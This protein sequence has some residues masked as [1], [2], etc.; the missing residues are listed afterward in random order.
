MRKLGLDAFVAV[1]NAHYLSDTSAASVAIVAGRKS[2]L[3][4]SRME[5]DRAGQQSSIKDIRAYFPSRVPLR[6]GERASFGKLERVIAGCLE[7]LGAKEIGFDEINPKTQTK[8]RGTYE[9]SYHELPEL[10]WDLREIKTKREMGWLRKSAEIARRGMKRAAELI[11]EGRSELEIAAE[12]EYE[13]R[14]SGSEGASF[15]TIVASGKNSWLPHAGATGKR[16]RR[17]ELVIVDLGATYRGYASDMTRT[18]A[19]EPTQKQK[20]LIRVAKRAQRAAL[21][22]IKSGVEAAKIDETARRVFCRAGYERFCLHGSGHGVG[23]DIH[24]PPSLSA[25]SEDILRRG[26]VVTVE[27]GVYVRGVGGARFEDMVV[28]TVGGQKT[29]TS[30]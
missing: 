6:K 24:E 14:K 1:K 3:L 18:F 26:M 21:R 16:L 25:G 30:A 17:G 23:L 4:C 20:D 15:N 8:L 11:E 10:I 27:P 22:K 2:I 13:M 7:E 19:L 28:V 5:L 29:L 12:V 9:A